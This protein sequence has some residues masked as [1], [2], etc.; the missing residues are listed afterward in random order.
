MNAIEFLK[1]EHRKAKG[2]FGKLLRAPAA[3][4][5]QLWETLKPE[6]ELHEQ[7]EEACLYTPLTQDGSKDPELATWAERHREEVDKVAAMIDET[8]ELNPEEPRWMAKIKTIHQSLQDHIREEE[9]D[10]LPRL[11]QVW[12]ASRLAQAGRDMSEMKEKIARSA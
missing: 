11:S 4:R 8:G 12:D 2:A 7:I 9:D 5:G 6:L 3:D 1:A 10:I